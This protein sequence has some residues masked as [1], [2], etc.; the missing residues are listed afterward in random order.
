MSTARGRPARL[1]ALALALAAASAGNAQ[2]RTFDCDL[3]DRKAV[4]RVVGGSNVRHEQYPWQV[5]IGSTALG[6]GAFARHWC[7]GSLIGARWVLTAAHCLETFPVSTLR[8]VHGATDLRRAGGAATRA[9][10]AAY[11]HPGYDGNMDN[12]NDDIALLRLSEPIA[13]ARKSYA[14]LPAERFASQR[15][16]PGACSVVTGWGNTRARKPGERPDPEKDKA[17]PLLQAAGF[18]LVDRETCLA[19]YRGDYGPNAISAGDIC[20]GLPEGGRDSC[21]GDSGGPL[22]VEGLGAGQH[23]LVGV[24]SWGMGCA[25]AGKYGVYA[26]VSHYMP[27]I[28][29]T[30]RGQ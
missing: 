24:V 10:E 25:Q 5:S 8:V 30:I 13:G 2:Q 14:K 18:P 3:P 26:R 7:G 12:G 15:S 19:A 17:S 29:R 21:Q 9:V 20:A 6:A 22:V 1:P 4:S 11:V 28:V 16:F 23:M 27:W